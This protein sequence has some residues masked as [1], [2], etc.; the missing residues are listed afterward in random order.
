MARILIIDDDR[1]VC[2]LLALQYREGKQESQRKVVL[3]REGIVGE[4]PKILD[5]L[6]LVARAAGSDVGV[7]ISGE[8]GTGKELFASAIHRNSRRDGKNFVV[9]DCAALPE[10]LVLHTSNPLTCEKGP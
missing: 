5:C 9:V 3:L 7:L 1:A 6:S 2:E 10:T 4:S 8:T